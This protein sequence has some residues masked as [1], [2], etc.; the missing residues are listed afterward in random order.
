MPKSLYFQND[1]L[2]NNS[3]EQKK[4]KQEQGGGGSY[5]DLNAGSQSSEILWFVEFHSLI[6]LISL[7]TSLIKI[8]YKD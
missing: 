5:F 7:W 2:G 3:I 4:K 8:L 1:M 6:L